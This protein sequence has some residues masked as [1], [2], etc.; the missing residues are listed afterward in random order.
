MNVLELC[1]QGCACGW[2]TLHV[3]STWCMLL[4]MMLLA[5]NSLYAE[6]A[7]A[8]IPGLQSMHRL[9]SLD[10]SS[11]WDRAAERAAMA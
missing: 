8:L 7:A 2:H 9:A 1:M 3:M 10:I 6:G 11:K 5:D 4:P